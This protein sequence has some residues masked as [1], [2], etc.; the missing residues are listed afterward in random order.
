MK[1]EGCKDGERGGRGGMYDR[2]SDKSRMFG[3]TP[4]GTKELTTGR[5]RV[6]RK[7]AKVKSRDWI[8]SW[9]EGG[10]GKEKMLRYRAQAAAKGMTTSIAEAANSLSSRH[11]AE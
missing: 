10:G 3:H 8:W 6:G 1:F 4:E 5:E 11:E 7:G 9:E 2:S